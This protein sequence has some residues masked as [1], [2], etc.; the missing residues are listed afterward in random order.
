MEIC[1]FGDGFYCV[2]SITMEQFEAIIIGGGHNGLVT[3]AY[4]AK[5]GVKVLLLE[6]I[7]LSKKTVTLLWYM[8][9]ILQ[10]Q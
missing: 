5:A 3:A 1:G 4:L 6:R 10:L 8:L 2:E 7:H 9:A